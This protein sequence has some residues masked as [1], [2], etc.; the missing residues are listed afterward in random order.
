MSAYAGFFDVSNRL[1]LTRSQMKKS[2][3]NT[4]Q[5]IWKFLTKLSVEHQLYRINTWRIN[6]E[7]TAHRKKR[8][9]D[10]STT[11]RGEPGSEVAPS[12]VRR[13][14]QGE[15]LPGISA[16]KSGPQIEVWRSRLK[17]W[18]KSELLAARV[19]HLENLTFV[20]SGGPSIRRWR[21]RV[22]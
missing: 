4:K 15:A 14:E 8:D 6:N 22:L 21:A 7:P 18:F 9:F 17:A 12:T 11:A 1:L 13:A 19:H 2:A 5:K 10:G 20:Y 3:W 16:P